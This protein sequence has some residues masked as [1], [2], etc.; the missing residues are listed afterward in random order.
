MK[1]FIT[2]FVAAAAAIAPLSAAEAY[3][4]AP[5]Q[6]ET[7]EY[8]LGGF[9]ELDAAY[10]YQVELSRSP[11]HSV[12]VE[13]PDFLMPYLQVEVRNN[14]LYLGMSALPR[15]IRHRV[16]SGR[17][18]L[19]AIVTMPSLDAIHL[20]GSAKLD[21]TGE[22]SAR[23]DF[24][25]RLSGAVQVN[26]LFVRAANGDVEV[27]GASKMSLSGD[28][29]KMRLSLTGAVNVRMALSQVKDIH[30]GLSG[31]S[32]LAI[33]G[34]VGKLDLGLSGA[35]NYRHEGQLGEISIKGS[36][37]AK[38]NTA[39][40]PASS[41]KVQMSGAAGA[42]IEVNDELSVSLSGASSLR[43]RAGDRLR[44]TNQSVSR[45]S[46]LSRIN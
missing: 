9:T 3:D 15:E 17:F 46:S 27:S 34:K 44:I 11:R 45:G 24:I 32:K 14:C 12:T 28:F 42:T 30:A 10:T 35:S 20:S 4:P 37:A 18:K 25:A 31:A 26:G 7:K 21:A 5:A 29:D 22:F 36:G 2:L 38:V 43:F 41:A 33:A 16:E 23:K 39:D 6:Y 13:A 1:R 8:R 19:R 40:A